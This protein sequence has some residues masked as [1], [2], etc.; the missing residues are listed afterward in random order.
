[1]GLILSKAFLV[2][3][4]IILFCVICALIQIN[5]KTK[6]PGTPKNKHDY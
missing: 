6:Q 4:G 2:L 1:M 3:T 5:K